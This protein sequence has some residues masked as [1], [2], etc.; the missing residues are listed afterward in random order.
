M[1]KTI[2]VL[3]SGGDAPGMNAA[4]RS[5]VRAAMYRG[6]KVIGVFRGYN[7]LLNKEVSVISGSN[8]QSRFEKTG[9]Y[10]TFSFNPLPAS[11]KY[12]ESISSQLMNFVNSK[13]N[14]HNN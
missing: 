5:V 11:V 7:G 8:L 9:N 6:M 1:A 13:L 4:V 12:V 3:T 10:L 2:A 14:E